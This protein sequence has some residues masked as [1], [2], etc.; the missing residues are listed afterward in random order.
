MRGAGSRHHPGGEFRT[1]DKDRFLLGLGRKD[2]KGARRL[3]RQET[4]A[5]AKGGG[6]GAH[7]GRLEAR[8]G[9]GG[10]GE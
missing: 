2:F 10:G 1:A 8:Q 4:R 7:R 9:G 5:R 6:T 3:L